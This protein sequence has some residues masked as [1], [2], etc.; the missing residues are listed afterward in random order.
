MGVGVIIQAIRESVR[1][2]TPSMGVVKI[3]VFTPSVTYGATFPKG[4]GLP[5]IR[6]CY[7]DCHG[8]KAHCHYG[9]CNYSGDS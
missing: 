7:R 1:R 4:E 2:R 5:M 3:Y 9:A 6:L 8:A